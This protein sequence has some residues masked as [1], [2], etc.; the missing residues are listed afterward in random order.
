MRRQDLRRH[1]KMPAQTLRMRCRH[2]LHV[3]FGPLTSVMRADWRFEQLMQ[4]LGL[5][6]YW[7][8]TGKR[9]DICAAQ[10]PPPLCAALDAPRPPGAAP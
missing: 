3:L 10:E 2:E 6:D 7:R 4:S 5:M 9:P 8:T 1:L